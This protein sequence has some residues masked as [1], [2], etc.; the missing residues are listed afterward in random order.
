MSGQ[1]A[2][3]LGV[4]LAIAQEVQMPACLRQETR[5]PAGRREACC[6]GRLGPGSLTTPPSI[7]VPSHPGAEAAKRVGKKL[8]QE[9]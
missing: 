1:Q 9:S 5:R 8:K 2:R 7:T 3:S 4:C 6:I